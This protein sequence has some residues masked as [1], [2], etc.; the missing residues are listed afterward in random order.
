MLT[1]KKESSKYKMSIWNTQS[2][3]KEWA[4]DMVERL[5]IFL[6]I[7]RQSFSHRR[8]LRTDDDG[9]TTDVGSMTNISVD[10]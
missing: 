1:K 9:W 5:K 3:E 10:M 7:S 2:H 6:K 4:G 8:V